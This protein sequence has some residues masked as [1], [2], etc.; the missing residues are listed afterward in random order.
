MGMMAKMRSLAPW[1][2]ITVGGLFVL[3]MV[4]SDASVSKLATRGNNIIGYIGDDAITYSEFS[5]LVEKT[6]TQQ[7]QR[8]GKEIP[9]EQMD[10]FRDQVW[11]SVVSQRLIAK[12]IKNLGFIIT[13]N[14][15]KNV[16]LGP[17]PPADLQR[18]FID[19]TGKFNRAAYE[20][21]LQDPRNKK[22]VIQVEE[23]VRQQLIQ[24]KLQDYLNA[25]ML[26]SDKDVE[27]EYEKKN[28]KASADFAFVNSRFMPDSLAT[29]TESE[30][31]DYYNSNLDEYKVEEQRK[32]KYVLFRK[33]ASA[34]DSLDIKNNLKAILKDIKKDTSSFKTY[35]QIYSNQ[36]YSRDTLSLDKISDKVVPLLTKAKPGSLIGPVLTNNGYVLVN[37]IGKKRTKSPVVRASHILISNRGIGDAKAK[38]KANEVY[39][40]LKN[41]ADFATTAMKNSEDPGSKIKGGDLGWFGKGQ[42]VPAF[43]KACFSGRVGTVQKPIKTRYGYHIIKVTNKSNYKYIIEKIT[44]KIEPSGATVDKIN[45]DASDFSYLA[46]KND[47]VSEANLVKY[48]IIESK[49]F[50]GD[51]VAISGL[52]VSKPLVK[53]TFENSVGDISDVY[54][55][56]SGYVVAMVSEVIPA[57]HK[58]L[59]KVKNQIKNKLIENKKLNLSFDLAKKMKAAI[60]NDANLSL[61]AKVFPRVKVSHMDNIT[62]V[63]TITS[64]GRDFIFNDYVMSGEIN[65]VSAPIKGKRGSYIIRITSRTKFDSTAFALQKNN[66]RNYLMQQQQTAYF[67]NWVENLK[68][69]GNVIDLRYKFYK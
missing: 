1:F 26:V 41:G 42:M 51:A 50:K 8:S 16:L 21:A 55:V 58:P 32:I 63:S 17:N 5:S 38:V 10:A 48:Q 34:D 3:F 9:A 64:V 37:Y 29:V 23:G 67:R 59:A 18:S 31:K 56:P 7:V 62:P 15:I 36:P 4:F 43:E 57:G 45:S 11:E 14:E 39:K 46:N 66:L 30:I 28:L 49:P 40:Q 61:A 53:F 2:I 33:Q 47:F 65:K 27:R 60:G 25:T 35:V 52:G 6:R 69:A 22:I 68:K 20:A 44:N 24:K 19:S 54:K 12:E 13:D